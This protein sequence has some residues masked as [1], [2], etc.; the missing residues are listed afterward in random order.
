MLVRKRLDITWTELLRAGF[1]G[2]VAAEASSPQATA[3]IEAA[4]GNE[5]FAWPC[6]SVRTGFDATLAALALP[7]GSEVLISAITIPGMLRIL[8]EHGLVPVPIEVEPFRTAASLASAER[9]LTSRTRAVLSASL[10]GSRQNLGRLAD[11]SHERGLIFIADEAQSFDGPESY[12]ASPADVT[13]LSFGPIK[14]CTALAGGALLFR[15]Q[16][17]RDAARAATA[18][19]AR[20]SNRNFAGRAVRFGAIKALAYGPVADLASYCLRSIGR[21]PDAFAAQAAQSF[22]GDDFFRKIR[23]RPAPALLKT[24]ARRLATFD[25]DRVAARAAAG[26]R[27]RER[28]G[29]D[30]VVVSADDQRMTY[31]TFPV[32]VEDP[33]STAAALSQRG[34]DAT[35]RSS[36]T[37]VDTPPGGDPSAIDR[38]RAWFERVVFLPCDVS[39]SRDR[40]DRLA[41]EFLRVARPFRPELP[42]ESSPP[43]FRPTPT[44]ATAAF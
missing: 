27:L 30:F 19:Y 43:A 39:Y 44:F 9:S 29:P 33:W 28:I 15:N 20:Q 14:T 17:L 35:A 1:C 2:C 36:L 31:W 13:L 7:P 25:A 41:A 40:L 21:D 34:Y 4:F 6:L 26:M 22:P 37:I 10:F 11:W 38:T 18:D 3:S 24:L 8:H 42:E 16:D 32:L 5:V 12:A 23:R